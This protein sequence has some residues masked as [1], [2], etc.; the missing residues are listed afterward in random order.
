MKALGLGTVRRADE[1]SRP[2]LPEAQPLFSGNGNGH[3][4]YNLDVERV[5]GVG[6]VNPPAPFR[7]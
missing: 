7:G 2:A 3:K 5:E 1:P 6:S 4:P